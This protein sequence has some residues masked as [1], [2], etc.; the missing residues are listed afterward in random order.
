MFIPRW[1]SKNLVDFM[2]GQVT[3]VVITWQGRQF[4]VMNIYAPNTTRKQKRLWK[5][6]KNKCQD[7]DWILSGD[8]NLKEAKKDSFGPSSLIIGNEKVEWCLLVSY[9]G[10][11]DVLSL[12]GTVEGSRFTKRR[13]HGGYLDQSR[14][15]QM[16]LSGQG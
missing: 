9:L 8:F 15:Y 4:G 11:V 10:L 12:L 6:I 5:H 2:K 7:V 3:W 16:Y 14:I 1:L 13:N